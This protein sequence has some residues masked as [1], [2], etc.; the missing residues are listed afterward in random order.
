MERDAEIEIRLLKLKDMTKFLEWGK[1]SDSRYEHYEFPDYSP[2]DLK[3]WYR[4]KQQFMKRKVYIAVLD[5]RILGYMTIKHIHWLKRRAELGIVFDPAV[6]NKGYGT[7][8]MKRLLKIYFEHMNMQAL[9][10]KV[11]AFN[12]RA[13]RAYE[14]V[15]FVYLFDKLEAFEEQENKFKLM[16]EH[17]ND[18]KMQGDILVTQIRYME[19]T[20]DMYLA[21]RNADETFI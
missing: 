17:P 13:Q 8:S 6:V 4:C 12:T 20:R 18:F 19:I 9:Y 21:S 16:L 14:K 10:L 1:H 7:A 2:Y 15:G 11:S 5:N 3:R